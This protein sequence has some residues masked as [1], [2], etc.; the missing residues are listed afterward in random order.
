VYNS[1][2]RV[3]KNL[4]KMEVKNMEFETKIMTLKQLKKI[5]DK[6]LKELLKLEEL[7]NKLER[8]IR[9]LDHEIQDLDYRT[10]YNDNEEIEIGIEFY[11]NYIK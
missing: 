1:I 8:Q 10:G 9:K 11:N 6:K 7:K 4:I 2:V 3:R 5:Y